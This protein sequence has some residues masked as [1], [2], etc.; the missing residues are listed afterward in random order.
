MRPLFSSSALAA[1]LVPL[2]VQAATIDLAGTGA[3]GYLAIVDINKEV[4][5][6]NTGNPGSKPF[7]YPYYFEDS[8]NL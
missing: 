3:S 8:S 4:V 2:A 1:L 6:P 5:E 7:D